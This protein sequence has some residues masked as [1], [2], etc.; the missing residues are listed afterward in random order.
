MAPGVHSRSRAFPVAAT[1]GSLDDQHVA[2]ADLD[3]VAA[4]QVDDGSVGALHPIAAEGTR[5]TAREAVRWHPAVAGERADGHRLPEAKPPDGS[6][7]SPPPA[8]AATGTPYRE[9]VHQ[10]RVA[11]LQDLWIGQ[12]RVGHV[13]LNDRG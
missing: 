4:V 9:G 7:A 10:H 5:C 2:G 3:G 1:A 11:P 8:V 13:R 12:P 6:V